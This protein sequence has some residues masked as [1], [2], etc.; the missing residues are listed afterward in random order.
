MLSA[1]FDYSFGNSVYLLSCFALVTSDL[2]N[3]F[4]Q[5]P[6]IPWICPPTIEVPLAATCT[7]GAVDEYGFPNRGLVL[8]LLFALALA[9]KLSESLESMGWTD[10]M[11]WSF[12]LLFLSVGYLFL[13]AMVLGT[14]TLVTLFVTIT[15][16]AWLFSIYLLW[17]DEEYLG[18][19]F[20]FSLILQKTQHI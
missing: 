17:I 20:E 1:L 8:P 6:K 19:S 9:H 4:L 12:S 5:T 13:E 10:S 7:L 2:L 15:F 18:K 11:R 16:V 14:E 3:K